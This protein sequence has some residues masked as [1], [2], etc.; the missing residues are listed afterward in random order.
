MRSAVSVTVTHDIEH[1][2]HIYSIEHT[3]WLTECDSNYERE[4]WGR[5]GKTI[6]PESRKLFSYGSSK[7]S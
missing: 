7:A 2:I 4:R 6:V 1:T 5:G 3:N